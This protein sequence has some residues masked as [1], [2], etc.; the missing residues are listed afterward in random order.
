MD[1][2]NKFQ[3]TLSNSKKRMTRAKEE[4]RREISTKETV[5]QWSNIEMVEWFGWKN[6]SLTAFKSPRNTNAISKCQRI[7]LSS[8]SMG[9]TSEQ[10]Q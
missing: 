1:E 7:R 6:I 2:M 8:S 9:S 10:K 3:F 5:E 4:K